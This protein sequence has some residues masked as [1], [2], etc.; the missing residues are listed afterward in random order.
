MGQ[1]RVLLVWGAKGDGKRTRKQSQPSQ[2]QPRGGREQTE[3]LP[4]PSFPL[5]L[6]PSLSLTTTSPRQNAN[7]FVDGGA[8]IDG[9]WTP[10][11]GLGS[12]I[13]CDED[14]DSFYQQQQQQQRGDGHGGANGGGGVAGRRLPPPLDGGALSKTRAA[15]YSG[16][17]SDIFRL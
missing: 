10:A 9:R 6:C 5:F 2:S 12:D 1:G 8:L 15:L 14:Y 11:P 13:R 16:S 3:P 7:A 4:H 17:S